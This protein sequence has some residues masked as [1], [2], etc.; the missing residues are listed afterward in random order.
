M[1]VVQELVASADSPVV[2][3]TADVQFHYGDLVTSP[4][5]LGPLPLIEI[6]SDQL[7]GFVF[8]DS[9]ATVKGAATVNLSYPEVR[10]TVTGS[11]S[12]IA[13]GAAAGDVH[14]LGADSLT[15]RIL[16][17]CIPPHMNACRKSSIN[18][19]TQI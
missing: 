16:H 19:T 5:N 13:D 17:S 9:S 3:I 8:S 14:R 7:T 4:M 2:V 11:A 6:V 15:L 12:E 1:I 18:S 10:I